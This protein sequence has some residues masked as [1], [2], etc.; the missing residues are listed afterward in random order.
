VQPYID[1]NGTLHYTPAHNAFGT[2]TVTVQLMDNGGTANGGQ[3]T[4]APQTF[5]ITVKQ[6][7]SAARQAVASQA[8]TANGARTPTLAVD[9][10]VQGLADLNVPWESLLA[11]G[12]HT[13]SSQGLSAE[14]LADLAFTAEGGVDL[15]ATGC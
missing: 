4:S 1:P 2:A 5:T 14:E 9:Q 3:D 8:T 6:V 11:A 15:S 13:C 12:P 10:A 7:T